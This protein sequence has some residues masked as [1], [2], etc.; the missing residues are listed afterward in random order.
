M[1]AALCGL[2]VGCGGPAGSDAPSATLAAG[3]PRSS[4]TT[5]TT[6]AAP[7]PTT[8]NLAPPASSLEG[9]LEAAYL[10]SWDVYTDAMLRLDPSRLVEVYSGPALEARRREIAGL[11]RAGTPGQMDVEHDYE[12]V[13]VGADNA[14]VLESYL[15]HSVLLDGRTMEPIEADPNEVVKR[16]YVL[17]REPDGWRVSHINAA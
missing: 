8:T 5:S 10:R 4:T 3:T 1:T 11:A 9:E 12:I 2:A 17:T 15:N 16:E 6:A 14:L 7:E 13:L